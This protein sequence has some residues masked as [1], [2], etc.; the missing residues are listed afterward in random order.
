MFSLN[1]SFRFN[2]IVSINNE[3][4]NMKRLFQLNEAK[5]SILQFMLYHFYILFSFHFF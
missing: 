4:Q 5:Q 3:N 2:N 1:L